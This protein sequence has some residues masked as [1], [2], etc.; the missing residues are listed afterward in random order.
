MRLGNDEPPGS[1]LHEDAS[2]AASVA[3]RRRDVFAHRARG[4]DSGLTEDSLRL[5]DRL[6]DM[7]A[8]WPEPEWSRA[9]CDRI[10]TLMNARRSGRRRGLEMRRSR[11]SDPDRG[12]GLNVG[13]YLR[14]PLDHWLRTAFPK[15]ADLECRSLLLTQIRKLERT[16][17]ALCALDWNAEETLA[18]VIC[19][20]VVQEKPSGLTDPMAVEVTA[21]SKG[22]LDAAGTAA[23]C[24]VEDTNGP[25][26]G[27]L[28]NVRVGERWLVCARLLDDGRLL[29]LDGT[30]RL[31]ST[32]P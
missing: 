7:L 29:P 1:D 22:T 15:V 21:V 24:S 31:Q 4:F 18:D 16:Y 12:A 19:E 9:V 2:W 3:M 32:D 5:L 23:L 10:D 6:D 14:H 30:R 17:E 26:Q 25:F 27:S 20:V 28:I 13:W 11:E 8:K